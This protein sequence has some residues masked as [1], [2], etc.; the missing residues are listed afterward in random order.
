MRQD[1]SICPSG[2]AFPIPTEE[3]EKQEIM[4]LQA[5][6]EEERAKGREIVVVLGVG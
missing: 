6:V 4:R 3:E 5:R 1:V 2:E